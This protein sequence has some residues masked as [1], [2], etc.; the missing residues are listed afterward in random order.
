MALESPGGACVSVP[1]SASIAGRM[2]TVVSKAERGKR[3]LGEY[4]LKAWSP[5]IPRVVDVS[6]VF[7]VFGIFVVLSGSWRHRRGCL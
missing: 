3:R 6:G 7:D 4:S 2:I 5:V 1:V